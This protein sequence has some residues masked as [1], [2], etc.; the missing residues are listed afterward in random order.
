M[1]CLEGH[2]GWIHDM[3]LKKFLQFFISNK[4]LM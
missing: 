2:T 3:K 4:K 1:Q